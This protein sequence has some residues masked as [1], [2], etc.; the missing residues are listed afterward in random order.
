MKVAGSNN[1]PRRDDQLLVRSFPNRS[2]MGLA[3]ASDIGEEMRRRLANQEQVRII[4]AAAASQVDMLEALIELPDIDWSRVTAFQ[5][6]EYVE[7]AA[8]APQ[9]FGR[10]LSARLFDR[11]PFGAVHF[12]ETE[13][14]PLPGAQ[15]YARRLNEEPIDIVCLG[16]GA[17][18]HI[19][20]NDPLVADFFDPLDVK[21]IELDDEVCR[22]QQV[23]DGAF[24]RIEDVPP[25]AITLTIPR[26]MR[27]GRLFCVVPG[28]AKRDAIR[29]TLTGP[30]ETACPA[31]ILRLHSDCT[32][33]LDN[34]SDFRSQS[35]GL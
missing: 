2:E 34:G 26:L 1:K 31:S 14:D 21:V 8:D 23:D 20:F 5:M 27:A 30:I 4:F 11:L 33:F 17:N 7:L 12:I 35:V 15:E 19:A 18:G 22:R 29:R 10:W 9:R 25:R 24:A 28:P 13:P 3:A 32:L 16:I 6:D